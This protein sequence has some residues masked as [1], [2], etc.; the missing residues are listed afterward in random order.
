MELKIIPF[1]EKVIKIDQEESS[2]TDVKRRSAV[3]V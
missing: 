3:V 1:I 2:F